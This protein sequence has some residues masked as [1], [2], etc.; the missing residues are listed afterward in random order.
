MLPVESLE[1]EKA[2]Y[3]VLNERKSKHPNLLRCILTIPE[4]IFL[5]RLTVSLHPGTLGQRYGEAIP[6]YKVL[7]VE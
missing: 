6:L 3:E 4:G 5:E 2:I 1:H 7:T